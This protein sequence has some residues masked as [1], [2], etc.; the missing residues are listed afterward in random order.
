MPIH[1]KQYKPKNDKIII[2]QNELL[3]EQ[4]NKY[5]EENLKHIQEKEQEKQNKLKTKLA[6]KYHYLRSTASIAGVYNRRIL[7]GDL[8]E[9]NPTIDGQKVDDFLKSTFKVV[10]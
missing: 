9:P 5:K 6:L 8:E 3:L 1:D 10:G 7:A 2:F 4:M